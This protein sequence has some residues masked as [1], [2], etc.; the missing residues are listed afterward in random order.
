MN[1]VSVFIGAAGLLLSVS[2]SAQ[3]P[4]NWTAQTGSVVETC[5]SVGIGTATPAAGTTLEL[6][7]ALPAETLRYTDPANWAQLWFYENATA[8]GGL[9]FVG[10]TFP[11]DATRRNA[12]ELW[13]NS[14]GPINLF[15]SRVMVGAYPA[16]PNPNNVGVLQLVTGAGSPN[17]GR[18]TFGTDG[19]GWNF[20]I[21][22]SQA[23][24]VSDLVTVKDNGNVGI[25]ITAP[26]YKLHVNGTIYATQVIGAT[27]Q[28]VAEWVPA[29]DKMEPG[30]VVVLDRDSNNRVVPSQHAYD[31]AVAGVVSANPGIILGEPGDSK[32]QIA[33][34]GRVR[35]HVDATSGPIRVGDLLVTSDEP[36][37][38][39]KSQPV[40]IA[41]VKMHRPGT[42]IGKALEPLPAGRGEILVLLS[43]Q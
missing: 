14:S 35:V 17:S 19:S 41:G 4:C 13:N 9:L 23:G 43:L 16:A 5:G 15:A 39:M 26:L 6:N 27:Y 30:V 18:L 24:T 25:G 38:A 8:R 33:T 22:K 36:G 31:T 42:L 21:A 40:D 12:L 10:S 2:A 3:T 11:Y 37:L 7:A 32:A 29:G 1:K 34:T 20:A 28:D